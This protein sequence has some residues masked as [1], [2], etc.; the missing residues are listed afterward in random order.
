MPPY[1][2]PEQRIANTEKKTHKN[3]KSYSVRPLHFNMT[4]KTEKVFVED[5]NN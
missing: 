1:P 5:A 3:F 2:K 4:S